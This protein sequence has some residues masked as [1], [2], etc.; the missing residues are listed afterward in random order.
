MPKT[1]TPPLAEQS[2]DAD[3]QSHANKMYYMV[4][5]GQAQPTFLQI[6]LDPDLAV[7]FGN[8][9][10]SSNPMSKNDVLLVQAIR[11]LRGIIDGGEKSGIA[12]GGG[13]AAS[14]ESPAVT[15]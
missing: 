10:D 6:P 4:G 12:V 1:E 3:A 11:L 2:D 5:S 8:A 15:G 7:A 13:N 9:W 14:G